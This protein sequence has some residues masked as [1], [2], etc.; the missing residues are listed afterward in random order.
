M[1]LNGRHRDELTKWEVRLIEGSPIKE[2]IP[3]LFDE[4]CVCAHLGY[5]GRYPW[6]VAI[7]QDTQYH[8]FWI[9][10]DT[11]EYLPE[12][13][14]GRRLR[15][16]T[17]PSKQLK[18]LQRKLCQLF[19]LFPK[20]PANFA[21]MKNLGIKNACESQKNNEVSIA[22]DLTNFFQSHK[23]WYV[24]E[25]LQKIS[26]WNWPTAKFITRLVTLNK[27]LPQG[28]P[29]SP[30]LSIIL[31][32]DMD[33]RIQALASEHNLVYSRYADDMVFSGVDRPNSECMK[34]VKQLKTVLGPF[35]LNEKKTRIMRNRSSKLL[36]GWHA[37]PKEAE[38]LGL[39]SGYVYEDGIYRI[40]KFQDILAQDHNSV[41][42]R[43][44]ASNKPVYY[45]LQSIRRMLGLHLV[46]E[47]VQ[48]PRSK[49]IDLRMEA[50][51]FGL[52]NHPEPAKFKGTLAYIKSVDPN[53]YEK[54]RM[55]IQK[56]ELKVSG[57]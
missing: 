6:Y 39:V 11:K 12:P 49:Y 55:V 14:E 20:H 23:E 31:N 35:V 47:G 42:L 19:D 9:D 2:G 25:Q 53:K 28:T 32:Y 1:E 10:K 18:V 56:Y 15:E 30:I 50:M 46:G 22:V 21:F 5:S 7:H 4:T 41:V 52:G 29:T 17:A 8:K 51:T 26:G 57:S 13:I 33:E 38:A 37:N 45:Y 36:V 44:F 27:E 3:K 16:I 34:F 43:Y 54:L 48:Y 24:I 40:G